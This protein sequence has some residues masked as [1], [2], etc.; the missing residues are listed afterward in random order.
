MACDAVR[1][2]TVS[3]L[4]RVAAERA[5]QRLLVLAGLLIAGWL[6]GCAAQSAHAD[7]LPSPAQAV[8]Q[9]PVLGEAVATI[10]QRQPVHRVVQ[11]VAAKAPRAVEKVPQNGAAAVSG[12]VGLPGGNGADT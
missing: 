6:L 7:E 4:R 10:H 3:V 5:V 1:V 8:A 11:A 9:T 2:G 12:E